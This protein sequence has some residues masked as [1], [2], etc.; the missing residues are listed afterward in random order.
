MASRYIFRRE[1]SSA[2]SVRRYL[3][4]GTHTVKTGIRSFATVNKVQSDL[5]TSQVKAGKLEVDR[6]PLLQLRL[7]EARIAALG[8]DTKRAL[9]EIQKDNKAG[10]IKSGLGKAEDKIFKESVGEVKPWISYLDKIMAE[11]KQYDPVSYRLAKIIRESLLS[12]DE[13]QAIETA[14]H[15][16]TYYRCEYRVSG[17]CHILPNFLGKLYCLV[18]D[19]A[20]YIPYGDPHQDTLVTLLIGL[21]KLPL[22]SCKLQNVRCSLHQW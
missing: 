17:P 2:N 4:V 1:F 9:E 12:T 21:R 14:R 13:S 16:D 20:C 7:V 8:R 19:T 10:N 6:G 5:N 11:I 3:G 15:I 22:M 18:F